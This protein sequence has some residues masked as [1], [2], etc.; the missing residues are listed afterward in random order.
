M[1]LTCITLITLTTLALS[2]AAMAET[3]T[4]RT[5]PNGSAVTNGS[6]H[7]SGG[8]LVCNSTTVVTGADGRTGTR[9]RGTV[10]TKGQMDTTVSGT[11]VGGRTFS[12][13][14]KVT[15]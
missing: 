6:C 11:R 15:R 7:A 4:T 13:T 2:G 14:T 5:G 1:K 12:R 10:F 9:A 3:V 8:Q